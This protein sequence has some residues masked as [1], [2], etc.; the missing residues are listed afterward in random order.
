MEDKFEHI[1]G[2]GHMGQSEF[3]H[4]VPDE[5]MAK[6]ISEASEK[7]VLGNPDVAEAVR[8][9]HIHLINAEGREL[10]PEEI[11]EISSHFQNEGIIRR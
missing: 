6:E 9:G 3:Y 10:T 5:N 8:S 2:T 11:G 1:E 7:A 4:M